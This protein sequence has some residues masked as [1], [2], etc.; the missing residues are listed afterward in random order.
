MGWYQCQDSRKC[1]SQKNVCDGWN[2]CVGGSD[3]LKCPC[4]ENE[5][6]CKNGMCILDRYKCD[7][8]SDCPDHSDEIGCSRFLIVVIVSIS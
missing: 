7:Y 8:D 1:I 2:D 4:A 5:F 3:E 6:H